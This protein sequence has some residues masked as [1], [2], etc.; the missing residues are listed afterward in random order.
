MSRKDY[1]AL[2]AALAECKAENREILGAGSV[3]KSAAER[4]ADVLAADNARFDRGR[5]LTACGFEATP[6]VCKLAEESGY[7]A[8]VA[9]GSWVLDG[10]STEE[11]ARHL[12]AGIE[13]GDP[14]VLDSLPS[15]P[16][17]G[18]WA[19]S[20]LPADVLAEVGIRENDPVSDDVLSA[21]EDGYSRG[22]VD[23][24][25]RAARAIL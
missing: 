13:D 8:G 25:V 2:A 22:V 10:N 4:I 1:N 20:L 14:E 6:D 3:L 7:R 19:G 9:A 16:L 15:S 18:E 21:F 24:V 23:E 12:L 5:F 11:T 17:S